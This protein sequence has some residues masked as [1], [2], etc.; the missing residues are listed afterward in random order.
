MLIQDNFQQKSEMENASEYS[1]IVCSTLG[2]IFL[3]YLY[4]LLLD[5][6]HNLFET[7]GL[8]VENERTSFEVAEVHAAAS[9]NSPTPDEQP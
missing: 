9:M 7:F 6:F 4:K 8:D 3:G 2:K 5:L 1:V